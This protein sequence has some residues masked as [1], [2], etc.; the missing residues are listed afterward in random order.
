MSSSLFNEYFGAVYVLSAPSLA[1][2]RNAITSQLEDLRVDFDFVEG[3]D[4]TCVNADELVGEFRKL[5]RRLQAPYVLADSFEDLEHVRRE[6]RVGNVSPGLVLTPGCLCSG[7]GHIRIME[8]MLE[9]GVQS[10]LVL[11][12]DVRLVP[13]AAAIL[14]KVVA[15]LENDPIYGRWDLVKLGSLDVVAETEPWPAHPALRPWSRIRQAGPP[16]RKGGRQR[17]ARA[18]GTELVHVFRGHHE[19]AGAHCY[20]VSARC[21]AFLAGTDLIV[22][23]DGLLARTELD[24]S[25]DIPCYVTHPFLGYQLNDESHLDRVNRKHLSWVRDDMT[26]Q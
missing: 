3:I 11:E 6:I 1:R 22:N 16:G 23:G 13:D 10:A 18:D 4:G 8:R 9:D 12:D 5:G 19:F 2:R 7:L 15:E 26:R 25:S 17:I 21:A 24:P 20:A 14:G